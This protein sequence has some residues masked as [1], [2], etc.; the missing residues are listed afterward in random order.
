MQVVIQPEIRRH[1]AIL[2]DWGHGDWWIPRLRRMGATKDLCS[3][4]VNYYLRRWAEAE[5]VEPF[6]FYA[7]R[8][9]DIIAAANRKVLDLFSW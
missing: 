5:G 4:R 7:E 8:S 2:Q 6:T 3:Q 1:L 9:W